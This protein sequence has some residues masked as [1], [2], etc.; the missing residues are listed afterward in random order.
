MKCEFC[1]K[2]YETFVNHELINNGIILYIPSQTQEN[3]LGY[4]VCF[5]GKRFQICCMQY[6]IVEFVK[7]RRAFWKRQHI[8]KFT[9]LKDSKTQKFKQHN[10]LV[11][12]NKLGINSVYCAP[13]FTKN[14][15]LYNYLTSNTLI[16][17]SALLKP[18]H[19]LFNPPKTHSIEFNSHQAY[20]FCKNSE[21]LKI[22]NF[23]ELF[24]GSKWYS[25][26]DLLNLLKEIL[27]EDGG[28]L[29]SILAK[30]KI[31]LLLKFDNEN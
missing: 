27:Q 23:N 19:P 4:D 18:I 7:S 15:D 9:T 8:F 22:T 25:E 5:F 14:S 6:K 21:A 13:L 31:I 30:N 26:E 2:A 1:E 3:N 11:F 29:P 24:T 20:Q 10:L 16:K 17:N 12:L 28:Y